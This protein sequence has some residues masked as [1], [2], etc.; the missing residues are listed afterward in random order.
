VYKF[1][2]Q[3]PLLLAFYR[4]YEPMSELWNF[5]H[6]G[7]R[8]WQAAISIC[9]RACANATGHSLPPF[10]SIPFHSAAMCTALHCTALPDAFRG[11][12]FSFLGAQATS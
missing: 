6:L 4:D 8:Q 5:R 12:L 11:R 3:P 1:G 10:H 2:S 9:T 7:M